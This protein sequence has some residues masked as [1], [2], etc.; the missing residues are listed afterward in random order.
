MIKIQIPSINDEVWQFNSFINVT[1][2]MNM[3]EHFHVLELITTHFHLV[4]C[5]IRIRSPYHIA[6]VDSLKR[7]NVETM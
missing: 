6:N 4:K 2:L 1:Y 5:R 7:I 3:D